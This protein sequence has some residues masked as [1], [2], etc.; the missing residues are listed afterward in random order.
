MNR[1]SFLIQTCTMHANLVEDRIRMDAVDGEGTYQAIWLTRRLL[2]QFMPH[3][4]AH[5][6][7]QVQSGIAAALKLSMDQQA[8]RIER[9]EQPMP[10]VTIPLGVAPWLCITIHLKHQPDGLIWTLTDD[11]MIDA[12][13]ALAG[14]GIRAMLDVFLTSYRALGWD[15]ACFPDWAREAAATTQSA[16]RVLN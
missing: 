10:P 8:L 12:H 15:E 6:E 4:A 9:A 3:L 14:Q 11:R 16:P 5:A 1:A 7:K 13:M 2:D